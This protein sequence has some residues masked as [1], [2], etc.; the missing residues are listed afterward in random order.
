[1]ATKYLDYE[2]GNDGNDGSSF[3]NRVKTITG[4]LTAAR[5]APGDVC[6]IMRSGNATSLG[7]TATWTNKSATVTLASALNALITNCDSTWT[8]SANVTCSADTSVYRTSTG[9]AKQVIAAG[10]TTG[11]VAYF[12]TG[13]LNLS[14]YQGITLWVQ[15]SA[16][17]AVSTLSI[18]LCSD[19][20]GVTTVDT[21]AIPAITQGGQ[22]IPI[23]IDKGSALGASIQSIALYADL[24][25][26]TLDVYLDNIS[27]VK[28]A[29]NDALNLQSLIGKNTGNEL[30]W[31]IRG[32]NGTTVTL[33]TAPNMAV[34]TTAR[35]YY[36]STGSVTTYKRE[37]I[38]TVLVSAVGT[39]VQEIQDSGSAG[40]LI[41]FSGGW[42]TTDMTTQDG[43]TYF[44]GSSGFGLGIY[45]TAK[46]YFAL[47]KLR[48]VRYQD[49]FYLNGANNCD[50]GS[51]HG[52]NC[53]NSGV[54]FYNCSSVTATDIVAHST[55]ASG[56]YGPFQ[57]FIGS[58]WDFTS[59][60]IYSGLAQGWYASPPPDDIRI[61]TFDLCNN[62]GLGFYLPS[63]PAHAWYIGT[64]TCNDN[65]TSGFTANVALRGWQ[66]DTMVTSGNATSGTRF[67][68]GATGNI[69]VRSLTAEN[70][71][72]SYGLDLADGG[73]NGPIDLT[74][75][76]LVTSGNGTSGVH[77]SVMHG[78]VKIL[79]SSLA[80]GTKVGVDSAGFGAGRV[81][82]QNYNG[83]TDDHRVWFNSGS[84]GARFTSETSVRHTASGIAWKLSP[85]G[86]TFINSRNP[87]IFPLAKILCSA[88][89]L[90]TV[91]VW[92]RRTSTGL[93]GT[94]HCSG[95]QIAGVANDVTDS[96]GAAI[97]TWE[98][99]TI[100]FTP[101]VVGVVEIEVRCYGGTSDSL[102]VD[103]LTVTQA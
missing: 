90:V 95:G 65:G 10:F 2:G 42:N 54:Y 48:C 85:V 53:Y 18:R 14:A 19:V 13:T 58:I 91:K 37:T 68:D 76:N 69:I 20:A 78:D 88:S 49:G 5:I 82:F 47:D 97:D 79:K 92:L 66:I 59:L 75:G 98:E 16:A 63:G 57:Q 64:L 103:D 74:I 89:A 36:G 33:D 81:R 8:A 34:G 101:S 25:P 31:A 71:A 12:A 11:I 60:R 96:I 6:R 70:N 86:T 4:G 46:T 28:A 23:Y 26:G 7:I 9:S 77:L 24:D 50:H 22:W 93:T 62:G 87:A 39:T 55:Y 32:I 52:F 83:T 44:D 3:A 102:Y 38:K 67:V 35:G 15:V 56:V 29:G 80:E 51:F 30:W 17:L 1:M 73:S 94:L 41:T 45:S 72:S 40:N 43:E 61:T 21:L 99:Q 84:G 100:T 27:T